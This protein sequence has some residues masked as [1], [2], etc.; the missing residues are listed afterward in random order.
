MVTWVLFDKTVS[1]RT[2]RC[3]ILGIS[4]YRILPPAVLKAILTALGRLK[5]RVVARMPLEEIGR[6][7]GSYPMAAANIFCMD[8]LPQ[9]E[10]MAHN[11]VRLPG[12]S[13]H[14]C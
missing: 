9:A 1:A 5:Q 6:K 8:Y 10:L 7:F 2:A 12:F 13:P 14:L 3:N 11:K 4:T